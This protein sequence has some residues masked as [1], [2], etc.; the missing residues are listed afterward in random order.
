MVKLSDRLQ[1]IAENIHVG[2]TIA[3]IG[4]DHGL[5][6]IFLY[7]NAI[8]PF[9]VLIDINE[10]P[11][12]KAKKNIEQYTKN[13]N[14]DLRLGSGLEPLKSGEV[15]VVVIAG[16]G[17]LL[18]CE[19]LQKNLQKSKTYN[20]F[21]LQP[22]TAPEKLKKWLLLHGFQVTDEILV[23]EGRFLCE[24]IVAQLNEDTEKITEKQIKEMEERL[25]LEVNP[26]LFEKQDP[27]LLSYIE[28]KIRIENG[29]LEEI[30]IG[31]GQESHERCQ[32]AKQRISLLT[33][34]KKRI[35]RKL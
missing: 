6:P 23:R 15:D 35:G 27:L 30:L 17:G 13:S 9:V 8:S 29:I 24:I 32:Q 33:E 31:V 14:F 22:R 10:G 1:T 16:M 20:K 25:E 5:L 7:E 3:D 11:L 2:E 26:I 12:Q 4:T 34:M 18:M 28:N 19:I 21:V